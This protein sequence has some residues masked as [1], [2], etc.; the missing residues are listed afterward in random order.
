MKSLSLVMLLLSAFPAPATAMPNED[1]VEL[2]MTS[3]MTLDVVKRFYEPEMCKIEEERLR[4]AEFRAGRLFPLSAKTYAASPRHDLIVPP[5]VLQV[6]NPAKGGRLKRSDKA[7]LKVPAAALS[8]PIDLSIS[9]PNDDPVREGAAARK[10]LARASLPVAF[11]PEGTHFKEPISIT[12]PYD[13]RLIEAQGLKEEGLKAHHWNPQSRA[14]EALASRLNTA[15]KT[16]AADVLHFS[17]YQVLAPGADP[18]T[19][20]A[21]STDLNGDGVTDAK[22]VG[23][24]TDQAKGI[25]PCAKGD[26]NKDGACNVADIQMIVIKTLKR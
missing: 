6:V 26:I 12:I 9:H 8:Q 16:V 14:W 17:I 19:A 10:H 21:D 18:A 7:A 1:W 24:A 13:A 5:P 15:D 20:V 11:G 22:D 2:I 4:T 25:S 23:L 3:T